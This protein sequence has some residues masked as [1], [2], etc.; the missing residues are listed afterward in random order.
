MKLS[1]LMLTAT[2]LVIRVLLVSAVLFGMMVVVGY[3]HAE[4]LALLFGLQLA[5]DKGLSNV[6]CYSDSLNAIKLVTA[7]I[8]P[9]HLY[10]AIMQKVKNLSSQLDCAT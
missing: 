7:P 3:L 4:L 1:L 6:I 8:T 2:S 5:W 10:A 9:M